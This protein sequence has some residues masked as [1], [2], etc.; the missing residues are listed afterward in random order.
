MA[1]LH[2]FYAAV[3]ASIPNARNELADFAARSGVSDDQLY[4]IRLT[5][6]EA[7]TNAV[8]HAYE[9]ENG[10][11]E[12]LGTIIEGELWV[13]VADE[14]RGFRRER[15]S[16]GLGLGLASMALFSDGL[17]IATRSSRGLEVR[18][19]FTLDGRPPLESSYGRGSLASATRPASPHFSTTT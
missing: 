3:P 13:L 9:D 14:G 10:Q 17:T 15:Q 6:S 1:T 8:E 16:E 18:M 12:L 19:R 2:R 7:L 11:I 4:R 5:A